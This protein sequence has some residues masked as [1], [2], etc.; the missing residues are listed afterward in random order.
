M[1]ENG[2]RDFK[3]ERVKPEVGDVV[4]DRAGNEWVVTSVG[5]RY[6]NAYN[7][8]TKVAGLV[9]VSDCYRTGRRVE[10]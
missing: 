2:T 5:L 8:Q 4:S 9:R 10:L 3:Q 7:A 1:S 6:V